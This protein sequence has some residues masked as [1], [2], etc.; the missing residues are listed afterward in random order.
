MRNGVDS[1]P[2]GQIFPDDLGRCRLPGGTAVDERSYQRTLED[3]SALGTLLRSNSDLGEEEREYVIHL[4]VRVDDLAAATDLARAVAAS[5]AFLP[6]LDAGETT[7][8]AVDDQN[9][10]HR[11]FCDLLLPG[12]SRCPQQFDHRGP[13]GDPVSSTGCRPTPKPPACP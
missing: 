10:R 13:C 4:P 1:T 12:G 11:V 6:E 8:S 2:R 3:V 5:L 7:V 9:N